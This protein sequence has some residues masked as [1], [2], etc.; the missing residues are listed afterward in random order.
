MGAADAKAAR[1]PKFEAIAWGARG[2]HPAQGPDVSR[3][4]GTTSCV[5]LRLDDRILVLDAGTGIIDLGEALVGGEAGSVDLLI[6]HAHLD[7]VMGLPFFAPLFRP[8]WKV[9]L[10]FAGVDGAPDAEALLATV[11]SPPLTPFRRDAFSCD[12]ALRQLPGKGEVEFG[13]RTRL[14]TAP[15]THPGG[16]TGFRVEHSGRSF[17]YASDF[18]PDDGT[19]DASLCGLIQ[20]ADLAFLDCTYTPE[21]YGRHRGFGHADWLSAAKLAKRAGLRNL[22][23]FH[24][25]PGRCDASVAAIE[26]AARAVHPGRAIRRGDRIDIMDDSLSSGTEIAPLHGVGRK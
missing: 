9:T 2:S 26:A 7:H 3:Y 22:G 21:E 4:G 17:A 15:L 24:H 14:V 16:A 8:D 23:L 13:P 6:S 1:P 11:V 25:A 5:E 19:G 12:L 10:W 20:E 18:E